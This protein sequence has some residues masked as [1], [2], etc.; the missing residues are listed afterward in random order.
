MDGG[1]SRANDTLT[2][3]G[4]RRLRETKSHPELL[5]LRLTPTVAAE[6]GWAG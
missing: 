2:G 3:P 5:R 4:C 1:D 6:F